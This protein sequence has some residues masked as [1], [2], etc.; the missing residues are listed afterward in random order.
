MSYEGAWGL[1]EAQAESIPAH[2][3][4]ACAFV[5][6][7]RYAH[8]RARVA[9][10]LDAFHGAETTSPLLPWAE[11]AFFRHSG[12][13]RR[14]DAVFPRL[15]TARA[16]LR[17]SLCRPSGLYADPNPDTTSPRDAADA[18]DV[19]AQMALGAEYL[20]AMARA[21]NRTGDADKFEAERQALAGL[22]N[23]VC[24]DETAGFYLDRRAD[25]S[26]SPVKT[27]AGFWPLAAGIP[28]AARAIRLAAHLANPA[29]FWRVHA[30]PCLSA[31]HSRYAERGAGG[32]GSVWPLANYAIL[33]GLERYGLADLAVRAGDNHVT[34]IS[35]VFKETQA[36][37]ENYMPDYIEPGSIAQP[38]FAPTA[39]IGPVAVLIRTVLGLKVDAPSR[40]LRWTPRFSEAHAVRQLRLTDVEFDIEVTPADGA[41]DAVLRAS[42][43]LTLEL[44][45]PGGV[46][47]IAVRDTYRFR[48]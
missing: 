8:D 14:L 47:R 11:W 2:G 32:R 5:L 35:H 9:A 44:H 19:S 27:T 6:Y 36:Q 21:L 48:Y 40:T 29:E 45:L 3:P 31:D 12:D 23:Q 43:P 1:W 25:G 24:W 42:A 28:D 13:L 4:A 30:F 33:H 10:M 16:H 15:V 18:V 26:L 34:T 38:D 20:A 41:F 39:G 46:Q 22:I 7:A 17:D 37:W